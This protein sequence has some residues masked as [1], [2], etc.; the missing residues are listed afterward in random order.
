M[1]SSAL[2]A[3]S[4]LCT[5]CGRRREKENLL[6]PMRYW[7]GAR[8]L[9]LSAPSSPLERSAMRAKSSRLYLWVLCAIVIGGLIG[10]FAPET[11]VALKPLGDGF[12]SLIKMLIGPIIFLTVVIGIA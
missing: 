4:Q 6:V 1:P 11:G 9:P 12:I 7:S 5:P 10:H 2:R 3:P 8:T